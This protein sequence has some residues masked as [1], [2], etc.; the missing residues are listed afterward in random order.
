MLWAQTRA[1]L[2]LLLRNGEQVLLTLVIPL[3]LLVVLSKASFVTVTTT[4]NRAGFFV[5]GVMALAVMSAAFTGQAIGV[6]FERQ[7][8]VLK[9]LGATPLPRSVLLG[10]KTLAVL[11]VEVL[12]LG[13]IAVVG[14]LLG[15]HPHGSVAGVLLLVALGTA[16]FSGLGLLLGG[17]LRGLTSLAA[18]NI[19][20][21]LLLVLGGVLFP[22]S[23]FGGTESVVRLLPTAALSDGLRQVLQHGALAPARDLAALAVWAVVA[24]A[25]AVRYFRW[26]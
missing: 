24:L 6:G 10:A 14:R 1:E 15:W 25:A 23:H 9:R 17:T 2:T 13:L 26:E 21:F 19:L 11:A 5:P 20:W 18:A 12:Q 16:A 7:Y 22:L 4:D 3:G 8:G